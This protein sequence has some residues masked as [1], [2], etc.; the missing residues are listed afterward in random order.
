MINYIHTIS[1]LQC[2]EITPYLPY[3][4]KS[5]RISHGT[6]F[7]NHLILFPFYVEY[8]KCQHLYSFN[9][10]T[11]EWSSLKLENSPEILSTTDNYS[12]KPYEENQFVLFGSYKTFTAAQTGNLFDLPQL[13]GTKTVLGF[14]N[15]KIVNSKNL[16]IWQ[17]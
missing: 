8:K 11:F 6:R 2:K 3:P 10:K 12:I 4:F 9:L 13:T 1:Q 16:F 7:Q 14:L 5:N 15:A 17:K